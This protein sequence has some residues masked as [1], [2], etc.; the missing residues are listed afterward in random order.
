MHVWAQFFWPIENRF[1]CPFL[2]A[3]LTIFLH[4]IKFSLKFF[5]FY[6]PVAMIKTSLWL[7]IWSWRN[8]VMHFFAFSLKEYLGSYK[9]RQHVVWIESHE[10]INGPSIDQPLPGTCFL[11]PSMKKHPFPFL[12]KISHHFSLPYGWPMA[13]KSGSECQHT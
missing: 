4:N 6:M 11:V 2:T 1:L 3:L 9:E 10:T 12:S 8:C 5:Y 13:K 7:N